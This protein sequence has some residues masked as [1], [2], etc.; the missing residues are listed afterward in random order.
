MTC[1]HVKSV[2]QLVLSL[3]SHGW[4]PL[5][6]LVSTC[7]II[8]YNFLNQ[9]WN[10]FILNHHL[11]IPAIQLAITVFNLIQ[12]LNPT[13]LITFGQMTEQSGIYIIHLFQP[14][15]VLLQQVK[16]NF[17]KLNSFQISFIIQDQKCQKDTFSV[18][19]YSLKK[20]IQRQMIK[21]Q[22]FTLINL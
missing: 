14:M 8:C 4:L 2:K 13:A 5:D 6:G 22:P 21:I 20:N 1:F 18:K 19:F 15:E 17:F 9:Y 12:L 7:C 11:F 3:T 16:H 10:S